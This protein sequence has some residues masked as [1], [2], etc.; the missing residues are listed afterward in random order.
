MAAIITDQIRILNAKNFVAGVTTSTN[1]Y[2]SFIGLTNANDFSSTW[3]QDPPSPKDSFDEENQYWDSMVAL[4]KI[5]SSDVRQVVTKR[6]WS[7]GTTFD[8]YRHDYSRT[9]TAA[10]TGATNLYA[11]SY[12]VINSDFRVYICIQNGT[13]PDTPNGSPSLD[14]PTHIDLEPR[15]AGTSGDG[16]LWKYLY[17]IKPSDIVKFEATAFM[18]VP[19]DWGTSTE[20]ELVIPS[21]TTGQ[22][23]DEKSTEKDSIV[24][25]GCLFCIRKTRSEEEMNVH[26]RCAHPDKRSESISI[27]QDWEYE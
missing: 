21:K 17:S 13:T 26:V 27:I 20:N 24:L 19:L 3:D 22:V 14:E 10:V 5:N 18:P 25:Y 12:Y 9:K 1:A 2:Y 11:A 23:E 7:S 6:N 16:Y 15:A 8:M 4:K